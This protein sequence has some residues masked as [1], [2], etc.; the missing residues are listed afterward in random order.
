MQKVASDQGSYIS[1]K[2]AKQE[3]LSGE[4]VLE[5]EGSRRAG[6]SWKRSRSGEKGERQSHYR[7][8]L[9]RGGRAIIGGRWLDLVSI[10][11]TCFD[12]ILPVKYKDTPEVLATCF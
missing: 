7:M 10:S 5:A 11:T 6:A 3:N 2:G 12:H 1:K 4:A 9:W 8:G